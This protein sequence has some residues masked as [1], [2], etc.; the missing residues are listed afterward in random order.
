MSRALPL[1]I[2]FCVPLLN[3]YLMKISIRVK[4][5]IK[6]QYKKLMELLV[7]D[8]KEIMLNKMYHTLQILYNRL[9]I[10]STL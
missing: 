4:L 9:D 7:K 8:N 1:I 5:I 2:Q 10:F 6:V 3:H